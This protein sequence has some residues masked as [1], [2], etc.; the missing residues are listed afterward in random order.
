[1][2]NNIKAALSVDY[3]RFTKL[4][5]RFNHYRQ[6]AMGRA[7]SWLQR[8][9]KKSAKNSSKAKAENPYLHGIFGP[10]DE[11]EKHELQVIGEIPQQ[12][13]GLL[14]RIGPNPLHVENQ[15]AYHWFS[16]DGML[17]AL[18]IEQGKAVW[19]KSRYVETDSIQKHKHQPVKAGFRRGPGDV[20]NT[21]AFY[22]AN[23][24]WA[25]VEAG[26]LPARLDLELN[27]KEHRLFHTDADLPFSA[28]P[29][30]DRHTGHLHAICYDALDIR[31]AYYEVIDEQGCLAHWAKI[32]VQHG[33]M[34]HDCA[35]TEQDVLIFDLPVTFSFRQLMKGNPLPY[36]WNEQHKARIGI[37][38]KYGCA[39]EVLWMP[40]EPCFIFHAANAYRN[41]QQQI[42]LDVVVHQS[43]FKHSHQGPFEQ[44]GTCLERWLIDLQQ[45][46]VD[47][48]VID[49]Q[50][51]EFPRIDE[52]YTGEKQ[53]YIYSVSF[54]PLIMTKANH[55]ICHDMHT[56]QKTSY[57]FG[58]QWVTGEV[59]YIPE[60]ADA[61]EGEGYLL[62]YVHH[63]HKESSK[64]VILK[65]QGLNFQ[66]QAE[67]ILGVHVPLGFHGNW[68]D[69]S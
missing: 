67:I 23:Q 42:V 26:A 4:K 48:K 55:L 50:A 45:K 49:E 40:I 41:E 59:V 60:S 17:H 58:E 14:L 34:I 24:I 31:H 25:S 6:S 30:K 29:H 12:L 35:I 27:T 39:D 47:R 51:Q 19:F 38:P 69:L 28:H 18:K 10:V 57:A 5:S 63:L 32:P 43:M 20:V 53:R 9:S 2:E 46:T 22:H 65:A 44:Q 54:D 7:V 15:D 36:A 33:P 37:L 3:P 68:V 11:V 16:G 61:A 8:R 21:N 52:R 1:M 64:V 13:T 62:S 66:S 56:Q